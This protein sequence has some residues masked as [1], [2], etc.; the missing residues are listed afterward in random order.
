M[1]RRPI[2]V[3]L[4]LHLTA[5]S[6]DAQNQGERRRGEPEP[7]RLERRDDQRRQP[8]ADRRSRIDRAERSIRERRNQRG[9]E[10]AA[11]SDDGDGMIYRRS[12]SYRRW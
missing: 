9:G 10:D 6:A 2:M 4:A 1:D 12:N 3:L 8:E 5:G 7:P 11:P